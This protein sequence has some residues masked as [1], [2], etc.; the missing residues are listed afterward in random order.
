VSQ[1][2]LADLKT[3]GGLAKIQGFGHR[4][5]VANLA[6]RG[7]RKFQSR[8]P[9]RAWETGAPDHLID[10]IYQIISRYDI[11][12]S[13][14]ISTLRLCDRITGWLERLRRA[15][16]DTDA[17]LPA[18]KEWNCRSLAI[19]AKTSRR[20][21]WSY[22]LQFLCASALRWRVEPLFFPASSRASWVDAT[23]RAMGLPIAAAEPPN[24][25][26]ERLPA[27]SEGT[28]WLAWAPPAGIGH[29]LDIQEG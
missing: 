27:T 20:G 3:P 5:E 14:V 10:I 18:R 13:R 25:H 21:S 22:S 29:S 4:Y 11:V 26:R 7:S 12:L 6:N 9:A 15:E 16:E 23:P 17:S 24:L 19:F 8:A 1:G 2:G 28:R